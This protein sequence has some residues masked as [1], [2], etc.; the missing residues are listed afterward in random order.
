M[1][2]YVAYEQSFSH[3]L[4]VPECSTGVTLPLASRGAK[5]RVS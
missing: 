5:A 4:N 3:E 1:D 2:I